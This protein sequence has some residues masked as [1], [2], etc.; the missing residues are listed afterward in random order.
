MRFIPYPTAESLGAEQTANKDQPNGYPGLDANGE[1][2]GQL[3]ARLETAAAMAGVTLDAGEFGFTT[4]TEELYIGDGVTEGGIFIPTGVRSSLYL[5]K[6]DGSITQFTIAADTDVARGTALAAA[7]AACTAGDVIVIGP[8][9]FDFG[10]SIVNLA[11]STV[12][13]SLGP[14]TITSTA[15]YTL[16]PSGAYDLTLQNVTVQNT[17]PGGFVIGFAD[18]STGS[19]TV[20]NGKLI[21]TSYAVFNDTNSTNAINLRWSE[22]VGDVIAYGSCTLN[23]YGSVIDLDLVDGATIVHQDSARVLAAIKTVDGTGSGL[24]ADLLDGVELAAILTKSGQVIN[25]FTPLHNLAPAANFATPDTRNGHAVLDFDDTTAEAAIFEGVLPP[26][27]NGGGLTVDIWSTATSATTGNVAWN[28][29]IER[30]GTALDIDADSFAAAN[31]HA[32]TTVSGTSG[33]A[34]KSTVTFTDGADMDSLAAGEPYRL[35]I[36]RD[37]ATDTAVGDI[38]LLRVLVREG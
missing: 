16:Q 21:A 14:A 22:V 25:T 15:S 10:A 9:T 38:E 18:A 37:V 8:G 34:V 5:L 13:T 23:L 11:A 30:I 6:D 17:E 19:L 2:I 20:I 27:Y 26:T 31:T 3:I 33:I 7:I 29:Y 36:E 28:V 24:D 35:K 32:A 12:I 1:F 4:D